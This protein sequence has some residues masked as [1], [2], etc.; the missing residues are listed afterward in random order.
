[1]FQD[2]VQTNVL[3]ILSENKSVLPKYVNKLFEA[4]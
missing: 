1:M 3:Q 4:Q 2:S